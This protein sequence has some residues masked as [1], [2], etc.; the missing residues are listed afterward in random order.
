MRFRIRACQPCEMSSLKNIVVSRQS[1][2]TPVVGTTW[3]SLT[4]SD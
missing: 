4:T 1:L 2:S 3:V